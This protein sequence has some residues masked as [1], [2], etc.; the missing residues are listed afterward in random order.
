MLSLVYPSG[1]RCEPHRVRQG[2]PQ[3]GVQCLLHYE[4]PG[5]YRPR[6]LEGHGRFAIQWLGGSDLERLGYPYSLYISCSMG[7]QGTTWGFPT[8]VFGMSLVHFTLGMF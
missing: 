6:A 3:R 2:Q 5:S 1:L 4:L 7:N 8:I